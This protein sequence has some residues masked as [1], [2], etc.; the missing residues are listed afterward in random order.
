[1]GYRNW[2]SPIRPQNPSDPAVE[3]T[4]PG[5]VL[6]DQ[7]GKPRA[8]LYVVSDGWRPPALDRTRIFWRVP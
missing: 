2:H 4:L 6:F 8:T 3:R 1:M 5:L 7:V